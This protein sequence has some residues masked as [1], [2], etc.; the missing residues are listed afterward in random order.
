[1]VT[2]ST[3]DA[4]QFALSA[5]WAVAGAG[6]LLL[7][8]RRDSRSCV[9]PPFRCSARGRK[10][11]FY[12]LSTLESIYRVASFNRLGL[13]LLAGAHAWQRLR[14]RTSVNLTGR[15]PDFTPRPPSNA[16]EELIDADTP[17]II[18]QLDDAERLHKIR[19]ELAEGFQAL[20]PL[21]AAVSIFGS[22]R[23]PPDHPDYALARECARGSGRPGNAIITGGGP[24]ESWRRATAGRADAGVLSVGLGIE[25]PHEQGMNEYVDLAV[26]FHYFF[27]RKIMFVRYANAFVA[28]PGGI[29]DLRRALRSRDA[30]ADRQDPP[31]P[32]HPRGQRLL[33]SHDDVAARDGLADGKI[34]PSDVDL[35][36]CTDDIDEVVDIIQRAEYKRPRRAA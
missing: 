9:P 4:A 36:R 1:V 32:D 12:D 2:V 27:A 35:L 17:A 24:G 33:E 6:L 8:L 15:M 7:G 18:S 11:C 13:V 5:L 25:L 19:A 23:T 20:R 29:R 21:G 14:P 30:G 10:A 26:D 3:V 31:L 28:F 22:A 16:D 34:S